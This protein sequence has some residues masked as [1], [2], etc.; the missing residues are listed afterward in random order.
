MIPVFEIL[1]L[2]GL[3]RIAIYAIGDP[4]A[5]YN[6]KAILAKYTYVLSRW[7]LKSLG[8]IL[9]THH[10]IDTK[11]VSKADKIIEKEIEMSFT[12]N[13][14]LPVAGF[15]NMLGL[16]STCTSV[17]FFG[18]FYLLPHIF[19]SGYYDAFIGYGVCLIASR[20]TFKNL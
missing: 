18:I 15:L 1:G 14:C 9:P 2:V 13:E 20:F 4:S 6:P 11:L 16:C 12:V 3:L 7:R 17:W 5:S 19:S 8:V 10:T